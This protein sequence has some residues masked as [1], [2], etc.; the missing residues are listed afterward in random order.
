II[1]IIFVFGAVNF[2]VHAIRNACRGA[3]TREIVFKDL[4]YPN[5]HHVPGVGYY[6]AEH[7]RW[8]PLP[9]NELREAKGYYHGGT[10]HPEPAP[11][12]DPGMTFPEEEHVLEVNLQWR[13]AN[14]EKMDRILDDV[15][16][17]GFGQAV[18]S[19]ENYSRAS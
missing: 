19:I 12:P 13:R 2:L 6:H 16:R 11:A 17:R 14:P 9:W 18:E 15:E 10:W 3:D 5:N 7:R 1:L 8:F 4:K